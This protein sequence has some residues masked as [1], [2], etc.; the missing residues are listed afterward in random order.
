MTADSQTLMTAAEAA[1]RQWLSQVVVGL[2]LCPFA[3]YPLQRGR[4]RIVVDLSDDEDNLMTAVEAEIARLDRHD[5]TILE[6]TLLV[7]PSALRDFFDYTDFLARITAWIDRSGAATR[8]QVASFHPDYQF[9]DTRAD[10]PGNL[11]NRSPYPTLHFLRETSVTAALHQHPDV[12]GI[13]YRNI[14]TMDAL[15]LAQR[16]QLFPYLYRSSEV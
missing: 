2:G 8:Y 16:A 4:V 3:A 6:T 15:T 12:D 7:T 9:A 13:P 1:T 11:T 14:Q 5:A 10:D